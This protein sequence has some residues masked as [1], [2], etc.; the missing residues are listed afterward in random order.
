MMPPE[1]ESPAGGGEGDDGL[2]L[3]Q[4]LKSGSTR[5]VRHGGGVGAGWQST[6]W[7]LDIP[8]RSMGM[9]VPMDAAG[10]GWGC[11]TILAI[12]QCWGSQGM[13]GEGIDVCQN[14]VQ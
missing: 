7:R 1:E 5:K 2:V 9:V 3:L 6:Q 11:R 4:A 12:K 14:R 10:R 8:V 13:A